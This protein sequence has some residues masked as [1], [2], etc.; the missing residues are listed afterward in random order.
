MHCCLLSAT[1]HKATI[2]Q[3]A[4][5]QRP[6]AVAYYCLHEWPEPDDTQ[7]DAEARRVA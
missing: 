5:A 2:Q 7:P 1:R 6:L 4:W 3:H